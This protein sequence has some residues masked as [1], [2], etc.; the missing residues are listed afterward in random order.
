MLVKYI[1][2]LPEIILAMSMVI[3]PLVKVFR[4]SQT[5]KTFATITKISLIAAGLIGIIFYNLSFNAEIYLNSIYTTFFKS[6]VYATLLLFGGATCRWFLTQNRS[7]WRYY[8]YLMGIILCADLAISS[9]HFGITLVALGGGI[10]SAWAMIWNEVDET[11]KIKLKGILTGHLITSIILLVTAA[12]LIGIHPEQWLY[13]SLHQACQS[14]ALKMTDYIAIT[15]LLAVLLSMLGSVPFHF[16]KL[17]VANNAPLPVVVIN[18]LIMPLISLAVMLEVGEIVSFAPWLQYILTTCGILS[19]LFGALSGEQERV[20]SILENIGLY[21]IGAILLIISG[22]SVLAI[23]GGICYF[24]IYLIAMSGAYLCCYGIRSR[25]EN[26]FLLSE[27]SGLSE[28]KPYIS[29]ALLIFGASFIGLPPFSGLL[30]NLILIDS[31][32]P[33]HAFVVLGF[34]MVMLVFMARNIILLIKTIYDG[35]RTR[36]YDRSDSEVY[37]GILI[38]VI[39]MIGV[40]SSP[41]HMMQELQAVVENMIQMRQ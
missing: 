31:L 29:A 17:Q 5:A 8:Q 1:S 10:I 37:W 32:L 16:S 19:L 28:N 4:V 24:M 27:W 21:N 39:L 41:E 33:Q 35:K 9:R 23:S 26:L 30:G 11:A 12:M 18:I 34:V 36:K 20:T 3:L 7:S 2:L 38:C 6:T 22:G 40:V 13:K 15:C 25:G 14:K